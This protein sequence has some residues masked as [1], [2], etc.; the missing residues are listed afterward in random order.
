MAT[1][2]KCPLQP[3]AQSTKPVARGGEITFPTPRWLV[4]KNQT[5]NHNSLWSA[6]VQRP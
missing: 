4:R 5:S 3:T 2:G 1:A 6:E